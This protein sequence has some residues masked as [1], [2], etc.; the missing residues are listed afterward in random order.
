MVEFLRTYAV[1]GAIPLPDAPVGWIERAA[2]LARKPKPLEKIRQTVARTVFDSWLAPLPVGVRG[3][4]AVD[5][6]RLRFRAGRIT[7]DLHAERHGQTWKF[8]V[9][10]AGINRGREKVM[11][12]VGRKKLYPDALGLYQ[13]SSPRP[14][15]RLVLHLERR[16]VI[17]REIRWTHRRK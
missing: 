3:S 7:I 12:T 9:Q 2:G 10:A 16:E 4:T 1:A 13:W 8:L 14:P 11:L 5:H 15:I 6:R 17:L